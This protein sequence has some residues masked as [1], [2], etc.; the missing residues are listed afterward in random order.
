MMIGMFWDILCQRH[1]H[2]ESC[3]YGIFRSLFIYLPRCTDILYL[4]SLWTAA[5]GLGAGA[6]VLLGDGTEFQTFGS[7]AEK[8]CVLFPEPCVHR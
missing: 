7:L 6:G 3:T 5:G 2:M 8:M 4:M 1:N